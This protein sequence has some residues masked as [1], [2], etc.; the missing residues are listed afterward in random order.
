MVNFAATPLLLCLKVGESATVVLPEAFGRWM[1]AESDNPDVASVQRQRQ[2]D[3]R[4][5]RFDVLAEAVGMATVSVQDPG[6]GEAPGRAVKVS[7]T[8]RE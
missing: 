3:D 4:G 7:V 1:P 8:V 6:T 5:A 2:V